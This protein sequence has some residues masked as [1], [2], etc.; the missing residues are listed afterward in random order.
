MF[1]SVHQI[2]GRVHAPS[3]HHLCPSIRQLQIDRQSDQETRIPTPEGISAILVEEPE[4]NVDRILFAS[5]LIPIGT[6]VDDGGGWLSGREG[7]LL[8]RAVDL[9]VVIIPGLRRNWS[10]KAIPISRHLLL[11]KFGII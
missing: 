4:R 3:N 1:D 11:L 9:N 5:N 8:H 6:L 10:A 7:S 2:I